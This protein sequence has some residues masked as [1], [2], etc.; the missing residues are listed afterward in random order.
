[1]G[2]QRLNSSAYFHTRFAPDPR[3]EIL[4]RS[5]VK[6]HFSKL[7]RPTDCVLELGAGYCHFIN[8][9]TATRRLALDV[10]P[11]FPH[12]LRPHI[13]SHVGPVEDLEWV[14]DA[15][16]DFV[17]ASNLFE[18]VP[19]TVFASVLERLTRKLKVGGSVNILQP[20]YRFA[21]REYFDDYTHVAIYSDISL[22]DFLNANNYNVIDCQPRFMPLTIKSRFKV[23]PVFIRAYLMSPVRPLGKQ[24]L[25][26][27]CPRHPTT[28]A[29]YPR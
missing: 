29:A 10:W 28:L 20:N 26:R 9:V 13:E 4:W 3:R 25:V 15:S 19:Q 11:E 16:V 1:V 6:Y 21:Y 5:L 2:G 23:W 8:N 12:C 27:A 17:F 7:I 22:C 14:P 18:H 24:M